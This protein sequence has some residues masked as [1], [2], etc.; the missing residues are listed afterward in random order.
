MKSHVLLKRWVC[1]RLVI[2]TADAKIAG[3][4]DTG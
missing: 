1:E 4:R 2:V 3:E